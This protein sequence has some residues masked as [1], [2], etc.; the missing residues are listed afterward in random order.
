[1]SEATPLPMSSATY[2]CLSG[3]ALE[4]GK[5]K[6]CHQTQ[7]RER[8]SASRFSAAIWRSL[9]SAH[10]GSLSARLLTSSAS[11]FQPASFVPISPATFELHFT[12]SSKFLIIIVNHK[13]I[14]LLLE[15]S[16]NIFLQNKLDIPISIFATYLIR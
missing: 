16:Y 1:M 12:R 10:P 6:K 3:G 14:G 15:A 4:R 9:S 2:L 11:Q 8:A 13:C 7:K 5:E